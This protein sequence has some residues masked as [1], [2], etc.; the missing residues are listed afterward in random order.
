MGKKI[1]EPIEINGMTLKNRIGFAPM[2]NMPG[3]WTTFT[4]TDE[5]I[6]WFEAR[7]DG[8]AGLIMTGT[9]GPFMLDIPGAQE[10]FARL[11]E[12]VHKCGAKLGVQIG[13]GG[14]MLGMGPSPMPYPNESDPKLS[15]F[16]VMTGKIS[17]FPGI[18][19][20]AQFTVDQI[21]QHVKKFGNYAASIKEAGVD[22]VELHC[23]HGGATLFCSFISP[24]YNRREDEY[25]GNWENRLR[26]PTETLRKMREAVGKDYPLLVRISADELLGDKGITLQDTLEHIIP[27]MEDAG[28]DCIDVS[29]GS[30][31]H[32]PEGIMIPLY[33]PR[34]CYIHHAEAVK[35]VTRLPVI[36]VGRIVDL[37]MAEQFLQEGKADLIY[38]ARQLTSDP[39][40]PKKYLEGRP[41]EIRKCI[42]CLEGCGTPCPINYDIAPEAKPL[43]PAEEPKHVVVIGGGVGGMEAARICALRGHKV[44]LIEKGPAL[45][46]TVAALALDPLASEFDNFVEYLRIQMDKLPIHVV[47]NKEAGPQDILDLGPDAVIV[48]TGASLI[49]PKLAMES[50]GVMD[51]LEALKR[52]SEIGHRVVVWGLMYGAELAISLA[53]EGKNV[54]LLGEGGK[55]ALAAHASDSRR[56]WLMRKLT[57]INVVRAMPDAQRVEE[58][59]V[60]FN[61]KVRGITANSMQLEDEMG[62]KRDLPFDT[63]IISRGRKK[64]DSLAQAL[65]GKGPEVHRVGDCSDAGNIQKAVWGANVA[66]RQLFSVPGK[67]GGVKTTETEPRFYKVEKQ[68]PIIIWKF[69]NPPRN[70][71]SLDTMTELVQLVETFDKD[72][73][74]RVGI[75]TSATPG[76]FIQ[77][78]DVS[79]ILGWAEQMRH[80]SEEQTIQILSTFPPPR[81]LADYTSKPIICAINGPVEGGG[82]ELAL[83]CDFRFMARGAFMGQPEVDGGFPPGGGGT[84]RLARLVGVAKA[85][86]LCLTGRRIEADEAERLGLVMAVCEP[87]E[88]MPRVL[89]FAASL[90]DKPPAAVSLIKRAIHEGSSMSL[91]DGLLLE[92][93]LFFEGIKTDDALNRMRLYLAAGQ[94]REKLAAMLEEAGHDYEKIGELL[95]KKE[96]E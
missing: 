5:T 42:G 70:L 37:D 41:D 73:D 31:M 29:Q 22:C 30:I 40:T 93:K 67:S 2:L 64:N 18:E 68:G 75:V 54:V 79:L 27:A 34:G 59:K 25:G 39:E 55:T 23:A 1:F 82:C 81:G 56:W 47:L 16:E 71:A 35:G 61:T 78:F 48:A 19:S 92:R 53:K 85:L 94:D 58:P 77:H 60:L 26:F 12:A 45:G 17:P 21:E 36:G 28:A 14:P 62:E 57:D 32:S 7:A 49:M 43:I 50:P 51:H 6:K 76:M 89:A 38:L 91:P 84:Q 66:A 20:V 87:D 90:A 44:T 24:F 65:E 4:I 8:G 95:S 69:H 96:N 88:L 52:R 46:G 63:L 3:I 9:F 83:G 15:F 80:L 74:L 11:A 33:Y 72:P 86:E 10:R 13:D